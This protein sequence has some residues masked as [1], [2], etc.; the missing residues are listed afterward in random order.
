MW[1]R[2]NLGLELYIANN[3]ISSAN[4]SVNYMS[5][6]FHRAHPLA[7]DAERA[8]LVTMGELPYEHEKL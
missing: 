5:H 8:K 7:S 3:D 6:L 2:S 1:S 4:V